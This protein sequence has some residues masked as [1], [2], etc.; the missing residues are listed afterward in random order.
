MYDVLKTSTLA[1]DY[2]TKTKKQILVLIG[3][4][5]A[6]DKI[7]EE[8]RNN[9]VVI[10]PK[11]HKNKIS[12]SKPKGDIEM[13]NIYFRPTEQRYVGRKRIMNKTIEVYAKTQSECLY[14]LNQ[15]IKAL[16]KDFK[17]L[18]EI[19]PN[20]FV[21]CWDKWYQQNK[22][23]F[24]A[25]STREDFQILRKKL[26]PLF[27]LN[28]KKISK[29]VLLN[30]L[31]G[32]KNNRTKDKLVTQLKSFFKYAVLERLIDYNPFNTLIY[33]AQKYQAKPAFTYEQ[34]QK[35]LENLKGKEFEPIILFFFV[36]GIRK[37]EIDFKIIEKCIDLETNILT[38]RNL[39]GRDRQERFKRIKL[40]ESAKNLVLNN[41]PIFHK[42]TNRLIADHFKNFLVELGIKGSLVNCRHT[43]ATN[44]FYL[45]KDALIIS[46]E[47]GH[48]TS[49][50]TKDNYIDIDYNLSREKIIKLY[51]DLY[52]LK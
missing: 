14:K 45:E 22:E 9:F 21:A 36:T 2:A 15:K 27:E 38:I 52:N 17:T 24:I 29:D 18:T 26:T 16:K 1:F 30:Y 43:F 41:L 39:K 12:I 25:D 13:R 8:K 34:Q 49:S 19:K 7:I 10:T 20:T 5:E 28:I 47:M 44:C 31:A 4:L 32:V 42:Y 40:T 51:N 3:Y 48:S 50:I 11:S 35:I 46:R 37:N 23:P 6:E 33:K